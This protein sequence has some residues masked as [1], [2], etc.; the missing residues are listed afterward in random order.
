MGMIKWPQK[1]LELFQYNLDYIFKTGSLAEGERNQ[2]VADW[3]KD[4]TGADG[5]LAVNSNG[6][7]LHAILRVLKQFNGKKKV[8]IHS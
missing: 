2:K 8:F 7:G 4:Y 6:A 5:A 3:T 1:S